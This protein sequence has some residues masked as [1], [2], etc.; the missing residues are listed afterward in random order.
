MSLVDAP[1]AHDYI[2]DV[3]LSRR[4]EVGWIRIV[5]GMLF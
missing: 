2:G 3:S 4:L 1:E 5:A